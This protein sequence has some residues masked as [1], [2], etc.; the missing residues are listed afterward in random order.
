MALY[1]D[2]SASQELW[3]APGDC[4]LADEDCDD[5]PCESCDVAHFRKRL[6]LG[7]A[8]ALRKKGVVS[9]RYC[10][11]IFQASSV[12]K[13][14]DTPGK[15]SGFQGLIGLSLVQFSYDSCGILV[16]DIPALA[17][18]AF[19]TKSTSPYAA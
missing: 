15:G 5:A 3:I 19:Q 1:M 6:L 14:I 9:F 16:T 2:C 17:S 11:L 7:A 8:W 13:I 10:R 18:V 12:R 4:V